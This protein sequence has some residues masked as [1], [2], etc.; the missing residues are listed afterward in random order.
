MVL[1]TSRIQRYTV[2]GTSLTNDITISTP[3]G[4]QIATNCTEPY[5]SS[6]TLTQSSG[7]VPEITIFFRFA[8][9]AYSTFSGN[10]SHTSGTVTEN[11]SVNETNNQTEGTTVY[12]QITAEDDE[13]N[14]TTSDEENYTI[15]DG[16]GS[17]ASELFISEYIEGSSYNKAIEIFNGTGSSV[18]LAN[19]KVQKDV[20][21]DAVFDNEVS[22]SGSLAD[23]EVFVLCHSSAGASIKAEAD[24]EDATVCSF[25]GDDQVRLYKSSSASV[26]DH[27][28]IPGDINFAKDVTYIRKRTVASG[29][30][31]SP[32]D[33]AT[34]GEWDSYPQDEF[35]KR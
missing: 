15:S 6:I 30:P 14:I 29:Q 24:L 4:Y 32:Q 18:N 31:S 27:F 22:L 34:N 7:S 16:G 3:T 35:Y 28:G 13:A 26:I 5:G 25:N 1:Y 8:P 10:I 19:Y 9:N 33:P 21:G 11:I 12:Y 23:G 17:A 2:E 20:N